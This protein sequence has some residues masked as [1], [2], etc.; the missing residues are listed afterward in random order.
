M[1][2]TGRRR[3]DGPAANSRLLA[4]CSAPP[5]PPPRARA[6]PRAEPREAGGSAVTCGARCCLRVAGRECGSSRLRHSDYP[7]INFPLE[8]AG[9]KRTGRVNSEKYGCSVHPPPVRGGAAGGRALL[10]VEGGLFGPGSG[11]GSDSGALLPFVGIVSAT[12]TCAI[13]YPWSWAENSSYLTYFSA[14]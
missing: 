2:G 12:G 8:G 6:A 13:Y 9:L 11:L 5:L 3:A 4:A 14:L 7:H 10:P 1:L